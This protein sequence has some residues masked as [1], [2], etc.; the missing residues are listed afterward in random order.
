MQRKS[1]DPE[2]IH[3]QAYRI[4]SINNEWYFVT[5]E[6][7]NVGPFMSKPAAE[8]ALEKFLTT[9]DEDKGKA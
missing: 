5:R 9:V 6:G 8:K 2:S 1:D 4:S 7:E 3:F